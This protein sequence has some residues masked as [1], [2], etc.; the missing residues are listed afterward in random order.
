LGI[1]RIIRTLGLSDLKIVATPGG[2]ASL[3]CAGDCLARNGHL[4]RGRI[5]VILRNKASAAA[6]HRHP[7]PP[8]ALPAGSWLKRAGCPNAA[9]PEVLNR[10]QPLHK[11]RMGGLA[12]R[13]CGFAPVL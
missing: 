11:A 6:D 8:A 2:A 13:A 7:P 12:S 9:E 1:V 3:Y 4:G 5:P 10:Q